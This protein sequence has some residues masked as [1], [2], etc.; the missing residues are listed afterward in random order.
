[1]PRVVIVGAGLYGL[2]AAKTYLQVVDPNYPNNHQQCQNTDEVPE[3]FQKPK[4]S[5][6]TQDET[7]LLLLESGS[8]LGGTWA[9]ERLYPNLLSQNSEGLYEFSD[10]PLS[11]Q[12]MEQVEGEEQT[13]QDT[14]VEDRFIPGWK[15]S[16][17]LTAWS[18]KW[19][20]P[21]YMRFNW[22]VTKISR[23]P[24]KEWELGIVIHPEQPSQ[25]RSITIICDKLILSPGLTSVPNIL[26]F[27]PASGQPSASADHVIHAKEVGQWCRDNLGYQPIPEQD[28]QSGEA[29]SSNDS[30]RPSRVPRR[31][32][33]YGGAKSSFDL[34][35]MFAT[36]HSKDP[37]FHLRGLDE[38]D[39]IEPVQVHW[40]I[41]DGG[42]GPAWMSPPRSNMPNGQSI[43]SDKVASTRFVGVLSPCTPLVPKRLTL[44][45][46]S[47]FLGWKLTTEGSWLA[48]I[49]HGNPIGRYF[50][51]RF[52]KALDK[53]WAEFAGYSSALDDGKMERLR[54]TNSI[55]YCGAPLGIANQRGFWD[56]VRAPN[57][58]IHRSVIESV[59]GDLSS[60]DGV[61]I[62][63]ADGTTIPLTNLLIQATGWKPTVPIEFSPPSLILQ[64]G[65]SCP[66][67]R[68]ILTNTDV[69]QDI[70]ID[71]EI[72]RLIEYW[73]NIDS[74]SAS[75]IRRVFGPNS[76][77]PKDVVFNDTAPTD[78]FE[79]S[80]YRLF[81]RMVAPELVEEGDRS[82]VALGF[83][84]T[85]T[86]A[87]VAE[88]Q[89]LWAAAFLTG[90]LDNTKC[91][92]SADENHD[93]LNF[94]GLT[95]NEI[96]RDISEDVVWGGL[97]GV[98]PGV[99]TLTYND[100]LLRDLGLC[101]YRM[102]GG[103]FNELTSVY[104]PKAYRGIVEEWK[105]KRR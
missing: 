14:P 55:I 71:A 19:H 34:V 87:V 27:S 105:T 9:E 98:G 93:A 40:I 2:I 35:H 10:M 81:R 59:S 7:E 90:G 62:T 95:R 83:V 53:S 58:H 73:E 42:S 5:Q 33:I 26:N 13:N 46:S 44:R 54:P 104:T 69:G 48:R 47:N 74:V 102:G 36:L 77:P 16:R 63:L 65:L 66:V 79:N 38:T 96:D 72:K 37:S 25:T 28:A 3:S 23:L 21:Q 97:T 39:A 43:A 22:Q 61:V 56:A 18:H 70:K 15:L 85:A 24:T 99:D 82:F 57:V 101:P 51:R 29:G 31:V 88:V 78:D 94:N 49:L 103:F 60:N 68:T 8:S 4:Y 52:W 45:R 91:S 1:M 80:P 41:R 6:S 11:E 50:V 75:R 100:M 32:A 17:Y 67:P 64:L 12:A 86:T 89:A 30:A 20:L 76:K 92:K 84:L